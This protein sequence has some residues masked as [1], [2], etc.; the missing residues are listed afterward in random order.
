M[1][2]CVLPV[3]LLSAVR[4]LAVHGDCCTHVRRIVFG[5]LIVAGIM[6]HRQRF[7]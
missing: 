4:D 7:R 2:H 3:L 6:G 5:A 1:G